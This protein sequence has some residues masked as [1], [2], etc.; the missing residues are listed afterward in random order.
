M[1]EKTQMPTNKTPPIRSHQIKIDNPG[2]TNSFCV[3]VLLHLLNKR[4]TNT[5]MFIGVGILI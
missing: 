5:N 1:T 3:S 4:S 2:V